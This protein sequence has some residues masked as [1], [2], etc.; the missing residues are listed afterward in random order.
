VY[1]KVIYYH[2]WNKVYYF[3]MSIY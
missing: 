1:F 3:N 2:H